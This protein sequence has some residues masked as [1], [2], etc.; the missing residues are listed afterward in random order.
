MLERLLNVAKVQAARSEWR[1]S[2]K[3]ADV[4]VWR[5]PLS[6]SIGNPILIELKT[7]DL[8]LSRI[9]AAERQLGEYL[10]K[11]EARLGL[12]LFLD[13]GGHRFEQA[14]S[15]APFVLRWD[16]ED[17]VRELADRSFDDALLKRRNEMVHGHRG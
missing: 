15:L 9:V 11:A 6:A 7:G 10:T 16:L 1:Q 5:D 8:S 12:L 14:P 4:A 2:D 3:G 13:R 17:F